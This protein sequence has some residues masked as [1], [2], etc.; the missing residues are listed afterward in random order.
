MDYIQ[1]GKNG[2]FFE[3]QSVDSLAQTLKNFE[4]KSV[5]SFLSP[6]EISATATKFSTENFHRK[7]RQF[8]E[9][10]QKT[11]KESK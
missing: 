6:Q 7:I 10:V 4:A 1:D 11:Q 8:V 5:N 2:L 3:E 9:K